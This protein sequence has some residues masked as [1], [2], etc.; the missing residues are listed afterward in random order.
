MKNRY[1]NYLLLT[2]LSLGT[3]LPS[4]AQVKL[5]LLGSVTAPGDFDDGATEIIAYDP[6]TQQVFSTNGSQKSLDIFDVS[7]PTD[8]SLVKSVAFGELGDAAQSVSFSNGIVAVALGADNTQDNGKVVFYDTDGML[9]ASVEVGALPD[10]LTFTPDGSKV[11]VACEGEPSDDYTVDPEGTI[12][13]IDIPEDVSGIAQ[14]AVTL[15]DFNSFND[16]K[17]ALI[18][19]GVRIFGGTTPYSVASFSAGNDDD[20]DTLTLSAITGGMITSGDWITLDSDNTDADADFVRLYQVDEVIEDSILVFTTEFDLDRDDDDVVEEGTNV[21]NPASQWTVYHND[22]SATVSEDLEPEYI[23]VSPDGTEAWATL[24]ENNAVAVISLGDPYEITDIIPLG[25]KDHSEGDNGIDGTDNNEAINIATYPLNG[26]YMPDAIASYEIDGATYYFT[27]NEGDAREY[28]GMFE[29]ISIED[30]TL[31]ETVF[32]DFPDLQDDDTQVGDLNATV[33]NGDTDGD[34]DFDAIWIYGARSFSVWNGDGLVWD[35][36][37]DFEQIT[38]Q[39]FPDHFNSSNDDASE[40]DNRSDNKGPEPEA[41]TVGE[42]NGVPY[43]FIA[44][45]R[46][47]GVMVYDVSDP[48]DP[49]Y[50]TYVNNRDFNFDDENAKD[51]GPEDVKFISP[52]NSPTDDALLIVSNEVSGTITIFEVAAIDTTTVAFSATSGTVAEADGTTTLTVSITNPDADNATTVDVALASGSNA[53]A[54]DGF[55]TQTVT[56]PAGS[57]DDQSVTVTITDNTEVNTD[58][59]VN[60]ELTNAN[61]AGTNVVEIGANDGFALTISDDDEVTGLAD[62]LEGVSVYPNPAQRELTVALAEGINSQ[63]A[64]MSIYTLQGVKVMDHEVLGAT[65]R[66]PVGNLETGMYLVKVTAGEKTAVIRF[67]VAR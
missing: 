60:F 8:I 37:D 3:I 55:L 48:A 30:M 29:E 23:A 66:I 33:M 13:V 15:L 49:E 7:D 11:L 9:L 16:Q 42:F 12:A 26:M 50:I 19:S 35:S 10:M 28:D 20:A 57:T 44:L 2:I 31:D 14:S 43:A 52:E 22:A 39:E 1:F 24:Q 41:I 32:A 56:F 51:L 67:Q 61:S 34:G 40:I 59:V 17:A 21:D 5:T 36:G 63:G 58:V 6:T 65:T 46:I 25:T 62:V 47:G 64:T 27:A 18:Q 38:A 53:L 45:E 54:V 4:V